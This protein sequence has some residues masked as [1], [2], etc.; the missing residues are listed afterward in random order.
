MNIIAHFINNT[1]INDVDKTIEHSVMQCGAEMDMQVD[2][3]CDELFSIVDIKDVE[4]LQVFYDNEG[5]QRATL[6][7]FIFKGR[8][9]EIGE[10]FGSQRDY[11]W[12]RILPVVV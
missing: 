8:K 7:S 11:F 5:M 4:E 10:L 9:C 12:V 3:M 6:I 1:I 2:N